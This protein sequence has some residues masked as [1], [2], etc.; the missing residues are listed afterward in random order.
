MKITFTTF[1]SVNFGEW[2]KTFKEVEIE[3]S[4]KQGIF[5]VCRR[6]ATGFHENGCRKFQDKVRNET[7]KRL[8]YLISVNP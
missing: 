6:L 2:V 4:D 7:L 3:M 5:C 8:D 1:Q